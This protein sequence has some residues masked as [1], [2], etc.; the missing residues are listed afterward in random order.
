M[1]HEPTVTRVHVVVPVWNGSRFVSAL[2][3]ALSQQNVPAGIEVLWVFVDDGSTDDTARVLD[4]HRHPQLRIVRHAENR[5]RA[6]ACNSGAAFGQAGLLAII[7]VDCVPG[8]M[9]LQGHL[10]QIRKGHAVSFGPVTACGD[11]FWSAYQRKVA[12]DRADRAVSGDFSA[13]TTAN[14]I[15]RADVFAAAG[16]FDIAYARYG[17]EDRDLINRL[18]IEGLPMAYA[19]QAAVMH[20]LDTSLAEVCRK[21]EDAGQFTAPL[22]RERHP[23]Q[24][25]AS[26]FVRYDW[27]ACGNVRRA[28]LDALLPGRSAI[29]RTSARLLTTSWLPFTA[30]TTLA[31]ISQ[32][33]AYYA[34]SRKTRD[35]P[36]DKTTA[37]V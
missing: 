9:W 36:R 17:F 13:M 31:R 4:D 1:D 20:R 10:E 19:S 22:Y 28:L 23:V 18:L 6:A 24:Y 37:R 5:G 7:D 35:L 32:A 15:M 33:L 26:A 30:K 11:E 21:M 16:G 29:A 12:K 3:D 8:P 2:L 14:V 34:G 27:H 25:A